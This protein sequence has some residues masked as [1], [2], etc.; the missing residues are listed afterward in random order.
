MSISSGYPVPVKLSFERT[1]AL[2]PDRAWPFLTDPA[3]MNRWSEAKITGVT[4]GPRGGYDEVGALRQVTVP[5][6]GFAARLHED[7][8]EA[9][10]HERFVYRVTGGGGLRNHRGTITFAPCAL[11]TALNWSVEFQGAV[12]GLEV[13]LGGI[14]RP[15]LARSLDVLV[16]IC[17]AAA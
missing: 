13:I 12:P 15:R 17:S 11:G 1:L 10:P 6:F 2:P 16:Q 8:L 4:P 5:A 3:L 14:L 9:V 7:V